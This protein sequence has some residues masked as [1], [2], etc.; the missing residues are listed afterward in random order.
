MDAGTA[1]RLSDVTSSRAGILLASSG[2]RRDFFLAERL[3][4]EFGM[5]NSR[6]ELFQG[7]SM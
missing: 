1:R 6:S 7:R 3:R 4:C 2:L 5:M